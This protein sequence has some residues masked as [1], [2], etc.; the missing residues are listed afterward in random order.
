[1]AT[2][3]RAEKPRPQCLPFDARNGLIE[4]LAPDS[5]STEVLRFSGQV[6]NYSRVSVPATF[7]QGQDVPLIICL[8]GYGSNSERFAH[9][10]S[11]FAEAGMLA[12][13]PQAPYPVVLEGGTLGFDWTLLQVQ[14]TVIQRQVAELM[15]YDYLQPLIVEM[16][17]RF[18]VDDVHILGFSQG[19]VIALLAGIFDSDSYHGVLTFGLPAFERTWFPD[20]VLEY[21]SKIPIWM[22]HG[23]QDQRVGSRIS[24]DAAD[25]L[26]SYDYS[27]TR[28]SFQGG[29]IIPDSMLQAAVDWI[30]AT[31]QQ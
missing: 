11:W 29:H 26:S 16:K 17:K 23:E 15:V 31:G 20:S 27:V 30:R 7:E 21:R 1:M 22:T 5:C 2:T 8:H 28:E 4:I 6:L 12:V 14:D 3:Q 19:A 13:V 9:V 24:W 18:S 25:T 10:G